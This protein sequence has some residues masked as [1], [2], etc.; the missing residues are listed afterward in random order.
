MDQIIHPKIFKGFGLKQDDFK[1]EKFGS[2]LINHTF[3]LKAQNQSDKD[4][5]LQ[6]INTQVFKKPER[7]AENHRKAVDYLKANAPN[8]FFLEPVSTTEGKDLLEWNGE[9]WRILPFVDHAI[10]ID[11]AN[12]PK[13][14]YEAAKQFGKFAKNISG[15]ELESLQPTIPD[16]HNLTLRYNDFQSAIAK[17][18]IDRKEETKDLINAFQQH[19]HI[20]VTYEELKTD[21]DFIDRMMHHDT[22]INNVMLDDKSFEGVCIIDLDT[23]MPGKIISD[24]GDM[25][26]TYVSPVSEE[27]TDFDKIVIREKYYDALM[28][29]YLS[30]VGS[31]LTDTEKEVLFY[32]GQ[33]MIYMQGLRFLT[34]FLNGDTY[35][36]IKYPK[37][38][39]NRAKNQLVLLEALNEKEKP[40]KR[41]IKNYL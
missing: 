40:L 17:A 41:I 16:F 38:N 32:S 29:G 10:T 12:N 6:R 30:Q 21:P 39:F 13:Q 19:S 14:A 27:E 22:K 34:D 15:L 3:R 35:Y 20:A 36:S 8:Y 1:I 4:L 26:R 23:M 25:I 28:N 37:H 7:I 11:E 24:L 5:I 31:D 33:F 2:G 9:Y 18:S